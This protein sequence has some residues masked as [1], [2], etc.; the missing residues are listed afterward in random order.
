MSLFSLSQRTTAAVAQV[1]IWEV[2]T[3]GLK[4]HVAEVGLTNVQANAAAYAWGTPATIGVTPTAPQ[5][6][7]S[8]DDAS[9][10]SLS[11]GA[12]AWGTAPT[13]APYWVRRTPPN[14]I[15]GG[16]IWTFPRG[17]MINANFSAVIW[18]TE[19]PST[20]DVWAVIWE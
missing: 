13:G 3:G 6:F 2:R 7:V 11:T 8:E 10:T 4:A 9:A 15:G 17:F 14:A 18:A 20:A 5:S 1:P 16:V 12:V 19:L